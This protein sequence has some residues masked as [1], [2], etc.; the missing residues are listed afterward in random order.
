MTSSML[1]WGNFSPSQPSRIEDICASILVLEEFQFQRLVKPFVKKLGEDPL[2]DEEMV[3]DVS[4]QIMEN[5][6]LQRVIGEKQGRRHGD[7]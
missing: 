4:E 3:R 2:D 7:L 5:N 6:L 1:V